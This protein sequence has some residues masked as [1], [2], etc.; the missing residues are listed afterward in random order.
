MTLQ[1]FMSPCLAI[2]VSP[3]G[4]SFGFGCS[5]G[6]VYLCQSKIDEAHP[7]FEGHLETGR[8]QPLHKQQTVIEFQP[9]KDDSFKPDLPQNE[10]A[11]EEEV[12]VEESKGEE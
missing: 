5:D 1:D 9:V 8:Y 11:E 2:D 12:A 10:E 4:D 7:D 3:T 6:R